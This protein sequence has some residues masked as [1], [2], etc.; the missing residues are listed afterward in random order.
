MLKEIYDSLSKQKQKELDGMPKN[1]KE[2]QLYDIM[3]QK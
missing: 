3:L 1:K 2:A